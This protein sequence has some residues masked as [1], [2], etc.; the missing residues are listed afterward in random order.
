M[1]TH[2]LYIHTYIHTQA[3]LYTKASHIQ[4]THTHKDKYTQIHM[5][6]GKKLISETQPFILSVLSG[7]VIIRSFCLETFSNA[8]LAGFSAATGAG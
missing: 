2:S 4:C 3:H 5:Q 1:H 8:P 6:K 7:M